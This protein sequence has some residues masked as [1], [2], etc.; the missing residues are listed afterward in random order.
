[1]NM[2]SELYPLVKLFLLV[3]LYFLSDFD[4]FIILYIYIKNFNL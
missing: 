2:S 4:I 1:M 3:E